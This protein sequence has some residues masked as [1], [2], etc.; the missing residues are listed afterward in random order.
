MLLHVTLW[1]LF[2]VQ[3]FLVGASIFGFSFILHKISFF[4]GTSVLVFYANYAY[5]IPRFYRR[6]QYISYIV[7]SLLLIVLLSLERYYVEEILITYKLPGDL[8]SGAVLT[9]ARYCIASGIVF[10]LALVFRLA[11]DW[12]RQEKELYAWQALKHETDLKFL[13]NQL[14]PHFLFNSI[15]NIYSIAVENNDTSA[16]LLLEIS[17]MLRYL[18]YK[19]DLT[20]IPLEEEVYFLNSL[21]KLYSL[22]FEAV[23]FTEI[24]VKGA[25]K[26]Y[27][28]PPLLLLPF[29]ENLFKHGDF[30]Q[31]D[32]TWRLELTIAEGSLRFD[33]QNPVLTDD[34]NKEAQSG[35]GLSNLRQRLELLFP[36]AYTLQSRI[37]DG[38]YHAQLT[39]N[40]HAN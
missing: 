13:K 40:L 15:N 3:G 2:S 39:L 19:I 30:E 20:R 37:T 23:P 16:P 17:Q 29:I 11:V 27:E 7:R 6:K 4:I 21:I 28:V 18:I 34:P 12:R 8:T 25:I 31:L 22:R 36:N 32:K 24:I 1:L 14:R 33:T 5:L 10:V 38:N 26:E 35:I 9:F